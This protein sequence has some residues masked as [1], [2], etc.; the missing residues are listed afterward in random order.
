MP[1]III[2]LIVVLIILFWDWV[3]LNVEIL[4]ASATALAFF[5][6]A[7]AAYE[8]RTSAKAALHAVKLTQDSLFETKKTTFQ[9]WFSILLEKNREMRPDVESHIKNN[10]ELKGKISADRYLNSSYDIITK[11]SIISAYVRNLYQILNYVDKEYYSNPKD[12]N[13]KKVYI[14]QISNDINDD[15]KIA[16]AMFGLHHKK[17]Q[18]VR[19]LELRV[20]LE[21]Y[22]FFSTDLFF[23]S[24][25][26]ERHYIGRHINSLFISE[27]IKPIYLSIN[28]LIKRGD[29][30]CSELNDR[31]PRGPKNLYALLYVYCNPAQKYFYEEFENYEEAIR[32]EISLN[33]ENSKRN[34]KDAINN[35]KSLRGYSIHSVNKMRKRSGKF[36]MN[37]SSD[38]F[39][40]LKRYLNDCHN[41]N[42]SK[43]IMLDD[44]YFQNS[45]TNDVKLG[46]GISRWVESYAEYSQLMLLRHDKDKKIKIDNLVNLASTEMNKQKAKLDGL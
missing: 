19:N 42:K 35:L 23:R 8:A 20:L 41:H 4:G 1:I 30:T 2:S 24:V 12:I 39:R 11:D 27:Y 9:N 32:S 29:Y 45:L 17:L 28:D 22:S 13:G 40:V 16:I 6:T 31:N 44:V 3:S 38:V 7:W 25:M 14:E 15:L 46:V 26:N 18:H 43:K 33:I 21:R 34:L 36:K 5:A 37:K 10:V